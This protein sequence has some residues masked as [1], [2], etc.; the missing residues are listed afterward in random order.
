MKMDMVTLLS[1]DD[2][3]ISLAKD[4]VCH[5]WR[6][7]LLDRKVTIESWLAH[8]ERYLD[9]PR[10]AVGTDKTKRASERS[11][12]NKALSKDTL[13]WKRLRVGLRVLDI[14]HCDYTVAITKWD[15]GVD[16]L[17][18]PPSVSIENRINQCDLKTLIST[19]QQAMMVRPTTLI[20]LLDGYINNPI[21]KVGDNPADKSTARGNITKAYNGESYSWSTFNQMLAILTIRAYT[22]TIKITWNN[23]I[24]TQHA[25]H[26]DV[27]NTL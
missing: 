14:K 10:S 19:L 9:S 6:L 1:Q 22:L 16:L 27:L 3:G 8:M 26:V 7:I 12:Q 15:M 5:L 17:K 24:V 25:I 11:S 20:T 21:S 13:P 23:D 18:R 2:K 4:G